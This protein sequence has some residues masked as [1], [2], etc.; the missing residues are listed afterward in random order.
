MYSQFV[1]ILLC[2][3]LICI[4]SCIPVSEPIT[5]QEVY[6]WTDMANEQLDGVYWYVDGQK[7]GK[8]NMINENH[9]CSDSLL[10]PF[11]LAV[12]ETTTIYIGN[13]MEQNLSLVELILRT[14][15][16]GINIKRFNNA[17]VHLD[18]FSADTCTQIYL[19]W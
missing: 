7:L 15:A 11:T 3:A 13:E 4:S 9:S 5:E 16:T 18:D 10:T 17:T 2:F 12:E 8:A 6:I 19:A 14:S 1:N